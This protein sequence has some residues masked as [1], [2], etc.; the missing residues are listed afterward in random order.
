MFE[1]I[2]WGGAALSLAGLVGLVWCILR[3]MKAHSAGLSDD[4]LRAAVQAVLPWNL[5]SLFLSVIG[6]M[7]VI[8]GISF[9]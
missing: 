7:L 1:I 3:V 8:L 9:G 2:T 4:E 6:L 5:A